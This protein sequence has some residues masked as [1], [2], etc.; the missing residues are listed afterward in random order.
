MSEQA[1]APP[2]ESPA[3]ESRGRSDRL[4][5]VLL[6]PL[7]APFILLLMVGISIIAGINRTATLS[8]TVNAAQERLKLIEE[9]AGDL[10]SMENGERGFILTDQPSFLKPYVAAQ[11]SFTGHIGELRQASEGQFHRTNLRL[12]ENKVNQWN[13]E[14]ARPELAARRQ[15]LASAVALVSTGKGQRLLN[16]ARTVLEVMRNRETQRL[17]SFIATNNTSFLW[18]ELITLGGL[19]TSA[20]LLLLTARKTARQV[21]HTIGALNEEARQV[22]GGHYRQSINS[23][24]I[25]ELD[26]L[27][28]EF[29]R[30]TQAIEQREQFLQ[31]TQ[32]ELTHTNESLRRSNRELERFAYVASHDLQEPLRTISSYTELLAKRYQ[33]Q[34][35]ERADRYMAFT[36]GATQRLKHLIQDLLTFS[37]VHHM[38]RPMSPVDTAQLV[39]HITEELGTKVMRASGS[40]EQGELPVVNGNPELLHHIFLNLISNAIKFRA[41]GRPPHVKV[42]AERD[43]LGW[44]FHVQDNGMGIEPQHHDRIFDVFQRLHGNEIFEGSGIGL[45][46]V[47]SAAEQ[48]GGNL[49]LQSVP[50]QG[51][52]F[53]FTLPDKGPSTG[54]S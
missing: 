24:G 6:R 45:A 41:E 35:D 52:T 30:M 1:P 48:H 11:A 50:G 54:K 38:D 36:I 46:I 53:S 19:V 4:S 23:S 21:T 10:N 15:S 9:V 44:T 51:S 2:S 40:I 16:E 20:V 22:A 28:A 26:A 7:L 34:L 17:N 5:S 33:G 43:A 14:A 32:A 49:W 13:S 29:N 37:R 27:T 39:Q 47:R 8:V 25:A 12:L 3:G 42:W 18:T 31:E